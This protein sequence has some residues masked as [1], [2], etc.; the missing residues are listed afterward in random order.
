M[1]AGGGHRKFE[2][3]AGKKID[4]ADAELLLDAAAA[5]IA[6]IEST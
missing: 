5:I 2:A 3:L 4:A 6:F 1:S